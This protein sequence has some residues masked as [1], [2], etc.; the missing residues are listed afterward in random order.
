MTIAQF[1]Y[2][3]GARTFE[4]KNDTGWTPLR[5]A[6]GVFRTATY[7]E[8]PPTAA[9]LRQLMAGLNASAATGQR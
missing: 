9:L 7:K 2:D 1:L 3:H 4:V 5:I 8:S 6:E